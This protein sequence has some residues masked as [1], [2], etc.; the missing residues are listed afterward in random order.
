MN[1]TGTYYRS[2]VA[3][4]LVLVAAAAPIAGCGSGTGGRVEVVGQVTYDGQPVDTGSIAFIPI[5]GSPGHAA[6]GILVAG[7]YKIPAAQG[8]LPGN[9]RVEIKAT[10]KTGKKIIDDMRPPG[11]NLVEQIEQFIPPRYN[12]NSK[13]TAEVPT[14]SPAK[15]DFDLQR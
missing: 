2:A 12:T 9:Y 14:E 5:D 6:G 15:L 4:S 3:V 11:E 8:P 1:T 13:L 7:R 10:R